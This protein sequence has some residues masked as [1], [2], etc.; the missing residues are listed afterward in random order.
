MTFAVLCPGQEAQ[1]AA[2]FDLACRDAEGLQVVEQAGEA[3][4]EDP[5]AWLAKGEAIFDNAIAQ[6]LICIAQLALW[7]AL[8]RSLPRPAAVAGY[9]VGELACYGVRDAL[10]AGAL[11]QLA[12]ARALAMDHAAAD[13]PGGVVAIRGL[14]RPALVRDCAGLEAFIAIVIADDVFVV[15]GTDAALTLVKDRCGRAGAQVT[16]LRVG[17]AS[18]TPLLAGAVAP[19]RAALERSPLRAPSPAV[20]AGIDA[21][22]VVTRERAIAT[23]SAQIA[24]TVEWA[25]CLDTLYERGCRVYLELGPGRAL[26]RMARERHDDIEARSVDEFRDVA[27]IV[28][29]V[30][31]QIASRN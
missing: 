5:R 8:R 31:R 22:L 4:A 24:S 11:A 25:Q 30:K 1:H 27:A 16:A 15:G 9:S 26:C 17:V 10:D 29:W 18:H 13:R 19:F 12:R 23:L 2:M 20:V 3:L 7:A 14:S 21:A 6:P 28:A